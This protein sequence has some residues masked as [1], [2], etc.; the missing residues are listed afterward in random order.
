MNGI[1]TKAL[2]K[3]TRVMGVPNQWCY[4][5]AFKGFKAIDNPWS[6]FNNP[7]DWQWRRSFDDE[8]Q[9]FLI[10]NTKECKLHG[11]LNV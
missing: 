10:E 4:L 3:N 2:F 11:G 5:R 6:E 8:Y 1:T 7:E 9:G